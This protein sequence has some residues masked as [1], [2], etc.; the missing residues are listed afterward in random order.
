M[1]WNTYESTISGM[2]IKREIWN[3]IREVTTP[4]SFSRCSKFATSLLHGRFYPWNSKRILN[5]KR[6]YIY[7]YISWKMMVKNF[8]IQKWNIEE[9]F[10]SF[11]KFLRTVSYN[12]KKLGEG[13]RKFSTFRF[14][15]RMSLIKNVTLNLDKDH[16]HLTT[17][18]NSSILKYHFMLILQRNEI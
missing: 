13:N 18:N 6:I 4:I 17:Y 2:I 9:Y 7:I 1:F 12:R 3:C 8:Y 5:S 11:Q 10:S 15:Q 14:K 16:I